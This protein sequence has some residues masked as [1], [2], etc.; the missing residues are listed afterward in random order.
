MKV[1]YYTQ[2]PFLDCAIEL[3]NVLKK[4]VE[5][6]VIIEISPETKTSNIIDV[7]ELP[8]EEVLISPSKLLKEKNYK[9]LEPYLE[10]T[11]SANFLVYAHKRSFSFATVMVGMK[12]G[13][14]IMGLNPDVIHFESFSQRSL[15]MIPFIFSLN[16]IFFTVHDPLPHSGES[17]WRTSL[18][19]FLYMRLAKGYF[20]YSEFAL[21]QF[22][23][24]YKK[25]DDPKHVL[26]LFPYHF[27][28][29]FKPSEEKKR[30]F[31]LFFGRLSPYKGVDILLKAMPSFLKKHPQEKLLIAGKTVNG[32]TINMEAVAELKCQITVVDKYLS[33]QELVSLISRAKVIVCP[34]KDATQSGVLMTAF[35]LNTPVIATNVGAFSEYISNNLN[36]MLFPLNDWNALSEKLSE[37]VQGKLFEKLEMNIIELNQVK[38]WD[39]NVATVI[40]AYSNS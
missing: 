21:Q 13:R 40:R 34:Y 29:S 1:V 33:N 36:G 35:A 30:E 39:E 25:V 8:Q 11:A 22:K 24:Y 14:F 16:K 2:T 18:A 38:N 27:Y 7:E 5:L 31:I 10:G 9:M 28:K 15:G 20:F 37:V 6:H 12:V 32:Y 19:K 26:S 23:N 4:H 3:I 17:N